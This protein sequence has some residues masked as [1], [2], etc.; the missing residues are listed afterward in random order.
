[1][2]APRACR[3][4]KRRQDKNFSSFGKKRHGARFEEYGGC[5]KKVTFPDFKNNSFTSSNVSDR[6]L[7]EVDVLA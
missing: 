4:L 7:S 3:E 5:G 2:A 1:M 6:A